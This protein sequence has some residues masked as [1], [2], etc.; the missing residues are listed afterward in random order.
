MIPMDDSSYRSLT[1]PM[2][3]AAGATTTTTTTTTTTGYVTDKLTDP[4]F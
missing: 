2:E 1:V 3:G 4:S